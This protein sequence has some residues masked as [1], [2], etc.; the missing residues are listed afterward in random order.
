MPRPA[1]QLQRRARRH[2]VQAALRVEHVGEPEEV[3]LVGAAAVVEDEQA[4]GIAVGGA[5]TV[6]EVAGAHPPHPHTE[7]S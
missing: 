5:L 3:V 7:P 6:H 1:G 4:G 2:D